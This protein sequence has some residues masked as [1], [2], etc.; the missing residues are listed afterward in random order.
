MKQ[1]KYNFIK[2]NKIYLVLNFIKKNF[3]LINYYI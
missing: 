1:I 2:F 3:R